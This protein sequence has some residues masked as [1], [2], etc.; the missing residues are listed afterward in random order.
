MGK[1]TDNPGHRVYIHALQGFVPCT[2]RMENI[3]CIACASAPNLCR[4]LAVKQRVDE[5]D[6]DD[7]LFGI[8]KEMVSQTT[9]SSS[10]QVETHDDRN[11]AKVNP[12]EVFKGIP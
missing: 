4:A 1:G 2:L 3:F 5:P 7:K 11:K 12:P 10:A 8:P 9:P 6:T